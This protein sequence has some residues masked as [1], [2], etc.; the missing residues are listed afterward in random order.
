VI[1]LGDDVLARTREPGRG[2]GS[3]ADSGARRSGRQ[4]QP[5]D[6]AQRIVPQ[7]GEHGRP[8]AMAIGAHATTAPRGAQR[9]LASSA[10]AIASAVSIS[11]STATAAF[12]AVDTHCIASKDSRSERARSST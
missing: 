6:D 10:S 3:G 12:A 9:R 1:D 2:T 8:T 7:R 4:Q 11:T 5:A